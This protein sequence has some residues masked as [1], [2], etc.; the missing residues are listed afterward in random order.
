[1]RRWF[2]CVVCV[3]V[4]SAA[5]GGSKSPTSPSSGTPS[6]SSAAGAVT[7]TGSVQG[8]SSALTAASNGGALT[9]VTVTVVGTPIS[10][11]VDGA[12]RFSLVNV[13][14]GDVQ[15]RVT[16]AGADATV[17]LGPVQASQVLE[18]VLVV[19]GQ[20]A[21]VDSELR[22]GGGES[23]L[24]GRVEALPPTTA[25]LAFKAAGRVVNTTSATL[26]TQGSFTRS[27]ADLAIGARVHVRG[28]MAGD[29]FTAAS[30]LIQGTNVSAPVEV[31]GVIDTLTGTASAFQF[32]VGSRVVK[33]DATT[34]FFG[35]GDQPD[36]F[37]SLKNGARVE[38][39]GEQRDGF[40]FAARIHAEGDETEPDDDKGKKDGGAEVEMKGTLAAVQG[41]CP[42]INAVVNGTRF[43][44]NASTSFDGGTCSSF[45]NGD[46]VEVKATRQA[47][48]SVVA[49]RLHKDDDGDDE[50]DDGD[51]HGKEAELEGRLGAVQGTCPAIASTVDGRKFTTTASTSFDGVACSSLKSGDRVNVKGTS[52]ADGIVAA[53]RVR[54]K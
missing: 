7:I 54:R 25:A 33:G 14:P 16:G 49:T 26:F 8:S 51:E 31:N 40:V 38:V 44:T 12:G 23:E 43:T 42:A 19:A 35:H 10:S 27:F 24:E 45:K 2:G 34:M 17:S 32:N 48:G 5:C 11:G 47:D 28:S 29:V 53:T 21:T 3:A 41:S 15:L 36:T 46:K 1:M 20:S 30:V 39:K 18:I 22:R 4:L 6:V 37:S 9:G 13:P 50:D 52:G